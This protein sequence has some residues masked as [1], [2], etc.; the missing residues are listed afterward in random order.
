MG[1]TEL[2]LR[3]E[4]C[5]AAQLLYQRGY[6]VGHDGNLSLRLGEDRILITPSGVSK[7]RLEPDM[8]VVCDLEGRVLSGARYPSS[9]TAMHLLVYEE[10]PDA[11]AVVHAHPPMA[12]AFAIRRTPLKEPYLTETVSGLGEVPVAPFAMP[13]TQEVPES[14]RPFVTHHRAV[15]LANHGA[16]AWGRDLWEA[17]DRMETVEQTAKIYAW[18]QLLGGGE[19]LTREQTQGLL[20]LSGRYE[21]LAGAGSPGRRTDMAEQ[22]I[23]NVRLGEGDGSVV[24]LDQSQL[25]NRVEYRTVTQLP[26]MVEAIQS[27]RVRGAPAIGIFAGYCLYV[28]ARQLMEQGL[29]GPA[30]LDELD[31]QGKVLVS[32]RPTAV[33]LAWAVGRLTHLAVRMAGAPVEDIVSALGE[34]AR[35]I[36]REDEEMCQKSRNTACPS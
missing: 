19:A 9:E 10:R 7:G 21:R 27:L 30:F 23:L 28:L 31:R 17:F 36:R 34:E 33:N 11:G 4:L 13:S 8:L 1:H 15:L 14:I 3:E 32:S 16:L 6:V 5:R 18:V 26:D 20:A 35:A 25:P 29:S 12:T 22:E 24:L 2:V